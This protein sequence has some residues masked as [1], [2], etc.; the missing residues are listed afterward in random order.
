MENYLCQPSTESCW[1]SACEDCLL[2]LQL[3]MAKLLEKDGIPTNITWVCWKELND[4][5]LSKVTLKDEVEDLVKYINSLREQFLEHIYIKREQAKSYQNDKSIT[6]D[7]KI[8]VEGVALVQV[9]F[10]ENY[11]CIAQREVHSYHWKQPQVSIFTCS[12]FY[13]GNQFPYVFLSDNLDHTKE[14]LIV[15]M[16]KIMEE[17]SSTIKEVRVWSD[18]RPSSQFK[19]KYITVIIKFLKETNNLELFCQ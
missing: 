3:F 6:R 18:D 1:I 4:G 5:R 19:N 12:I 7:L 13:N 8:Y 2:I 11:T 15:C 17:M 10:A 14:T 9:D 16:A